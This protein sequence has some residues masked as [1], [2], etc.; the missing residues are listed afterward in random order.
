MNI[1]KL[2]RESILDRFTVDYYNTVPYLFLG[3]K[4]Y[5]TFVEECGEVERLNGAFIVKVD[6]DDFY[7]YTTSS[8]EL[9]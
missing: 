6:E 7:L 5:K 9:K 2:F 1:L 4:Q 8:K 3:R